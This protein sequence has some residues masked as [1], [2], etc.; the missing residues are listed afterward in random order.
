MYNSLLKLYLRFCLYVKVIFDAIYPSRVIDSAV[1]NKAIIISPKQTTFPILGSDSYSM[2][3]TEELKFVTD[4]TEEMLLFTSNRQFNFSI[5][6]Y[7][8]SPCL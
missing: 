2:D 5:G 7:I 3:L 6:P 4:D 1:G 8:P